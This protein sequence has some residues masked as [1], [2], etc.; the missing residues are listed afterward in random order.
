[1]LHGGAQ[2]AH[3]FDE[4]APPIARTRHVVC[5]DQR[6]HEAQV[7][8]N[9]VTRSELAQSCRARRKHFA[10]PGQADARNG[11]LREGL[12]LAGLKYALQVRF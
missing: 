1:M 10:L 12:D 2:T 6:G 11:S 9:R 5:L 7:V 8:A 3:S 4:V